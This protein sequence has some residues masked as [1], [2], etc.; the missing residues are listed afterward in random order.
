VIGPSPELRREIDRVADSLAL[1]AEALVPP[2]G[3]P[4]AG[5]RARLL[6]TGHHGATPGHQL[7]VAFLP[8]QG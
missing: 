3:A 8:Y 5:I 6:R 7:R 4:P 2:T 1:S